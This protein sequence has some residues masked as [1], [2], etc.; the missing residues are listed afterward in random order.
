MRPRRDRARIGTAQLI[1]VAAC[2]ASIAGGRAADR[3]VGENANALRLAEE[4][5]DQRHRVEVLLLIGMIL[6]ADQV[7]AKVVEDV[8]DLDG[9]LGVVG[10]GI[11]EETELKIVAVIRHVYPQNSPYAGRVS[12]DCGRRAWSMKLRH[13]PMCG[14]QDMGVEVGGRRHLRVPEDV[15]HAPASA[16]PLATM[17]VAA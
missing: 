10:R 16:R 13:V 2:L 9:A 4:I 6:D 15:H 12:W 7:E 17:N 3:H 8:G 11:E 5:A 14:G 1:E